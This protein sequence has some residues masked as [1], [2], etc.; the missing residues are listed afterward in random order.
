MTSL[1]GVAMP[2]EDRNAAWPNRQALR[3]C[4]TNGVSARHA[5]LEFGGDGHCL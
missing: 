5:E 4:A 2:T 3:D 1:T